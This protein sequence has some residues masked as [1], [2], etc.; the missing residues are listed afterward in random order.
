MTAATENREQ[1]GHALWE[2]TGVAGAEEWL[3][4]AQVQGQKKQARF[5]KVLRENHTSGE[6]AIG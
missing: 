4:L 1:R 2:R 5:T 3:K 6:E